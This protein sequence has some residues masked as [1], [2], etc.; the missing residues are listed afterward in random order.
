MGDW[1]G[2]LQGGEGSGVLGGYFATLGGRMQ[3]PGTPEGR[4]GLGPTVEVVFHG[5]VKGGGFGGGAASWSRGNE[6]APRASC[7]VAGTRTLAA[8]VGPRVLWGGDNSQGGQGGGQGKGGMH[9]GGVATRMGGL[10]ILGPNGRDQT[11]SPG[12]DPSYRKRRAG[13]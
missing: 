3:N 10:R 11:H 2:R 9:Q 12:G 4:L 6:R 13:L 8:G 5:R 1:Y 7:P